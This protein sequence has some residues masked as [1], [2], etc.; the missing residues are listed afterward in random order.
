MLL[1]LLNKTKTVL[2]N[3]VSSHI[4]GQIK[5]VTLKERKEAGGEKKEET[6]RKNIN[7]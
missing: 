1:H 5:A 6:Q 7:C 2:C 4:S 3:E